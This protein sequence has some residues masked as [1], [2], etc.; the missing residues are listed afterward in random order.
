MSRISPSSQMGL[1][2]WTVAVVDLRSVSPPERQDP[3]A[4]FSRRRP[5]C[6]ADGARRS[7]FPRASRSCHVSASPR[8][9]LAWRFVAS[10]DSRLRA[11]AFRLGGARVNGFA[12]ASGPR[13][14]RACSTPTRSAPCRTLTVIPYAAIPCIAARPLSLREASRAPLSHRRSHGTPGLAGFRRTA[15]SPT[16]GE[17]S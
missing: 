10:V 1:M 5:A 13:S 14:R 12:R 16:P 8:R 9:V 4:I 2:P 15:L 6:Q 17:S 3:R 11:R 7:I